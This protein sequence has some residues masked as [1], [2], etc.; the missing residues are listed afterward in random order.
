MKRRMRLHVEELNPRLLPAIVVP[1]VPGIEVHGPV[2]RT[3]ADSTP[4]DLRPQRF[5]SEA[6]L[7]Q[8]LI[9][10]AVQQNRWCLGQSFGWQY[11][12]VRYLPQTGPVATLAF[13]EDTTA[14]AFS[15]SASP[16]F[17][18]TN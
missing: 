13:A 3:N 8:Y 11:P 6:A 16:A 2:V 4:E 17:S 5:G 12:T 1:G 15:A 14:V 10:Q 7:Q 18:Q 9:D